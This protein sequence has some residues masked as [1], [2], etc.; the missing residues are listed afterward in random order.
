MKGAFFQTRRPP[1][2]SVLSFHDPPESA[3]G[4]RDQSDDIE[5]PEINEPVEAVDD[6]TKANCNVP[7]RA[8]SIESESAAGSALGFRQIEDIF[9]EYANNARTKK[10]LIHLTSAK[11]KTLNLR[12]GHNII[13]Y[14]AATAPT[15]DTYTDSSKAKRLSANI[16]LWHHSDKIIISDIDGTITKSDIRGWYYET[17]IHIV[18]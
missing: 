11:L 3:F 14:T 17:N 5:S 12:Y 10:K 9:E 16:F 4:I 6:K 15:D 8:I 13:Q 2:D 18:L 1:P 7:R